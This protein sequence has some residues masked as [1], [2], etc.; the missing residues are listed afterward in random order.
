MEKSRWRLVVGLGNSDSRYASSYHNAGFLALNY[1]LKKAETNFHCKKGKK[2]LFEF[3]EL[4]NGETLIFVKPST[5][6]NQTGGAVA[7]SRRHFQ[8]PPEEI[9]LV[10]DDSDIFLGKFKLV[11]GRGAAGHHGVES[12]I[13]AL[14]TQNF[15]RLRIGIRPSLPI[16]KKAGDFVLRT[17]SSADKQVL[18]KV[19]EKISL[20]IF[21]S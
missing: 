10:H 2:K 5:L 7:A 20:E 3:F 17:I 6:M 14:N 4:K 1:F 13:N 15:W 12:T 21:A 8:I 18:E 9:L 19:F 16:R 11:F